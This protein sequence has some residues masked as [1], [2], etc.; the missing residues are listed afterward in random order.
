MPFT[1]A[2]PVTTPDIVTYLTTNFG[3]EVSVKEL[4]S[5]ADE[6]RCS[7][8]T[9]KKRLK[10][11]K[12]AIGKWNLSVKELEQTFKAPAATP[13]VQQVQSV[14]RSEQILVPEI[15]PNYVPFGNFTALKKIISSNVFYPTFISGLSGN[16]KT[17]GVE[18]ALSL[19]HISEPTIRVEIS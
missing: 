16:G 8:A 19:I 13:A 14:P 2:I 4:L 5:A 1:T 7:L 15:D 18:P 6:F 12:V 3:N 17:F 11:Y 9:I 10:T